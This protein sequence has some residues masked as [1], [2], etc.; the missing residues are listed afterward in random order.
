MDANTLIL[1]ALATGAQAFATDAI[2][3]A[4][5]GL[6]TLIQRKFEHKP[7]AQEILADYE[8]D[9][10]IYQKPLMKA[11]QQEQLDQDPDVIQA[12][13]RVM[14]LVQPQQASM[15][16]Y[17]I[18]I[19]GDVHGYAQGDNQNVTMNFGSTPQKNK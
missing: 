14:Q 16:K 1:T 9:P 19:T 15:G 8:G 17:N 13:Q 6:K 7:K 12:A 2:K 3:D 11:L 18:Q 5:Q 4:Y 10:D